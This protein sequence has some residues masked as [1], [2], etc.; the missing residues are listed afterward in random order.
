MLSS[1][2]NTEVIE[3][4]SDIVEDGKRAGELLGRLNELLDG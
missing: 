2:G 1:G 3:V 4:L